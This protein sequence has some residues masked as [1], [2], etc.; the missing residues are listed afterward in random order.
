MSDFHTP[1]SERHEYEVEFANQG[2]MYF[3]GNLEKT[4]VAKAVD[5]M[6]RNGY[7]LANLYHSYPSPGP[8]RRYVGRIDL[9]GKVHRP[10]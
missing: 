10:R 6:N 1:N 2:R 7:T 4:A 5:L 8:S 9:T 3:V